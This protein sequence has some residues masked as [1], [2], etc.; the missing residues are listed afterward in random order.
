MQRIGT[1]KRTI[2]R[3]DQKLNL[4]ISYHYKCSLFS[5]YSVVKYYSIMALLEYTLC[6]MYIRSI[7]EK[8]LYFLKQK[9]FWFI[10][11]LPI[12]LMLWDTMCNDL[13]QVFTS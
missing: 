13:K 6:A 9:H 12:A 4:L 3:Q 11:T 7:L 1:S 8:V 2:G 5:V 10:R